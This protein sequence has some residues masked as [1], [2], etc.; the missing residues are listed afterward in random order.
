M[1]NRQHSCPNICFGNWSLTLKSI[2]LPTTNFFHQLLLFENVQT[3]TFSNDGFWALVVRPLRTQMV[4]PM[5]SSI[6]EG[7]G[8]KFY[9]FF[10]LEKKSIIVSISTAASETKCCWLNSRESCIQDSY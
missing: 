8:R 5:E 2:P 10:A 3:A 6:F 4:H 7:V 9:L 1:G